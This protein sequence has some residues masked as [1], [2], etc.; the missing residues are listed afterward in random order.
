MWFFNFVGVRFVA[1]QPVPPLR[2]AEATATNDNS[3]KREGLALT[4][5]E[6]LLNLSRLNGK[7]GPQRQAMLTHTKPPRQFL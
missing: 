1:R 2:E 6:R 7:P 4:M 3:D 5:A